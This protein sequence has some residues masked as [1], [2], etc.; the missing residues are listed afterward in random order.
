MIGLLAAWL[1]AVPIRILALR[2][3]PARVGEIEPGR[4]EWELAL[5]PPRRSAI[6]ILCVSERSTANIALGGSFV[7]PSTNPDHRCGRRRAPTVPVVRAAPARLE[8][9]YGGLR[10][11]ASTQAR[12]AQAGRDRTVQEDGVIEDLGRGAAE[13]AGLQWH[14]EFW[15]NSRTP[16]RRLVDEP[17]FSTP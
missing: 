11:T 10:T 15:L 12:P 3:A 4:D 6:P 2:R 14:P 9:L 13:G 17:P 5:I 8:S 16:L 7:Q 1:T